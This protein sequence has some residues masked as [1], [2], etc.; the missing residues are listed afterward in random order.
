M[1]VKYGKFNYVFGAAIALYFIGFP[2]FRFVLTETAV[3]RNFTN[4]LVS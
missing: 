3:W 4:W 2:P 1:R